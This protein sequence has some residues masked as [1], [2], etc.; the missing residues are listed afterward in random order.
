[1]I[2]QS[3]ARSHNFEL[4]SETYSDLHRFLPTVGKTLV[5]FTD[6]EHF[7]I[8]FFLPVLRKTVNKMSCK[9]LQTILW[10]MKHVGQGKISLVT[11]H[12]A[13]TMVTQ[14]I[15]V[16]QG[17]LVG[18]GYSG[19][20][21]MANFSPGWNF[22]PPTW[23]KFC[24]DHMA[25]FSPGVMLICRKAFYSLFCAQLKRCACPSS[26]SRLDFHGRKF[27]TKTRHEGV[28]TRFN[29][30]ISCTALVFLIPSTHLLF[31]ILVIL[32][33]YCIF[34][35]FYYRLVHNPSSM[36]IA[37]I[38]DRVAAHYVLFYPGKGKKKF[39]RTGLNQ[40][41]WRHVVSILQTQ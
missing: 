39:P 8:K 18:G 30:W 32:R 23:L 41:R 33:L 40:S 20:D 24:C 5:S 1:M 14:C 25:N 6:S 37:F 17:V 38:T 36:L 10:D 3:P 12:T 11:A 13:V 15:K 16:N 4:A 7:L 35:S 26:Y 31:L 9:L 22:G 27:T 21:H 2:E 34:S 29:F 19:A 28:T